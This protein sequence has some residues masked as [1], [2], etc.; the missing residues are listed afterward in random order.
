MLESNGIAFDERMQ[1]LA[2]RS[3][4]RVHVSMNASTAELYEKSCWEGAGGAPAYQKFTHNIEH[5]CFVH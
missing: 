5:T 3:L 1:E 2:A 4:C